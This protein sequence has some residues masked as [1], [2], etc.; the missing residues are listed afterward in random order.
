MP[1]MA[2]TTLHAQQ[3]S[4]NASYYANNL[5]GRKMSNGQPY[6]RDSLTCAHRVFPLGTYLKVTNLSNDKSVVVKVTDR[7]PFGGGRIIDLSYAAAKEL[8]LIRQGVGL[9]RVEKVEKSSTYSPFPLPDIDY[10][11]VSIGYEFIPKWKNVQTPYK[12]E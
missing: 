6:H 7:G 5:H 9:V 3:Q 11:S 8:G 10:E 12:K 1:F 4:G 2:F